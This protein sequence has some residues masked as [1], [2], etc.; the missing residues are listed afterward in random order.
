MTKNYY[1]VWNVDPDVAERASRKISYVHGMFASVPIICKD[2]TCP[3]KNVCSVDPKDRIVG[4]RCPMEAGAIVERFN[5]WCRHFD[6]DI[7]DGKIKDEDL[8]DTTLIKDLVEIEVQIIRAENRIAMRGDFIAKTLADIDKKCRPYY[9]DAVTPEAEY[10]LT[11]M[12]KRYKI[13]QLLNATRK[14]K[15]NKLELDNPSTKAI[16]VLEK[17][18]NKLENV[19]LDKMDFSKKDD[20]KE[21]QAEQ[22]EN[23]EI[24][25]AEPTVDINESEE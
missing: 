2:M 12:D 9:Q 3:Y 6:I 23:E 20:L 24:P 22:L 25:S 18:S 13:L 16:N 8:A 15:A 14:D 4:G 17:I 5:S 11:L 7:S 1:D 19:D 21:K 10:K